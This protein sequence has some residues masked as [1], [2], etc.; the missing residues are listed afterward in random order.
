MVKKD[1]SACS[2]MFA[3]CTVSSANCTVAGAQCTM[4]T[5]HCAVYCVQCGA[6]VGVQCVMRGDDPAKIGR[7]SEGLCQPSLGQEG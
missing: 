5:S 2:V 4:C 1:S 6:L 7:R 3:R